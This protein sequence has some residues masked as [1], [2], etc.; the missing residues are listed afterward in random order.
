[1]THKSPFAWPPQPA[2]APRRAALIGSLPA[3]VQVQRALKLAGIASVWIT[4]LFVV[5]AAVAAVA[6]TTTPAS[7]TRA[8][9][10]GFMGSSTGSGSQH[11][12]G[13]HSKSGQHSGARARAGQQPAAPAVVRDVYSGR[14]S[15]YTTAF[16]VGAAGLWQVSWSYSCTGP[17]SQS[18][19]AISQVDR[20]GHPV[21]AGAALALTRAGRSGHGTTL[22][23]Q[24]PGVHALEIRTPCSWT[25]T[26]TTRR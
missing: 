13:R 22:A 21:P 7:H 18:G 26:V 15:A 23:L 14:G 3:R 1:M 8:T 19:F 12:A 16:T 6:M 17:A 20:P 10:A 25:V 5:I 2:R 9:Q 11:K 4:G 24:D